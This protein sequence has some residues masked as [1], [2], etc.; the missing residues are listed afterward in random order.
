MFMKMSTLKK[1]AIVLGVLILLVIASAIFLPRLI[2]LNR[3]HD[4]I[5]SQLEKSLGGNVR[6]GRIT[7]GI[8]TGLWVEVQ[9]FS[10]A[11]STAIPVDLE[12]PRTYGEI[13]LLPLLGKKVVI[14]DLVIE[15]PVATV[16][17][18]AKPE[19]PGKG[20]SGGEASAA[21]AG[22]PVDLLIRGV[23]LKNGRLTVVDS[24]TE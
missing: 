4:R 18:E 16:R 14:N 2:D 10:V 1:L 8:A 15:N 12:L 17:L 13:S 23:R 21:E 22:L 9:G 6:I 7:W 19:E 24:L 3:Y 5:V 11:G 20:G